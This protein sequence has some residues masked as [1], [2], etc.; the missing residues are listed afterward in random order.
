MSDGQNSENPTSSLN[1]KPLHK[2]DITR[3]LEASPILPRGPFPT[4]VLTP[5]ELHH[6][7]DASTWSD[8]R[9]NKEKDLRSG[10]FFINDLSSDICLLCYK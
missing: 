1:T 9:K 10:G 6:E 8:E 5:E 2:T 3:R 4:K 7:E